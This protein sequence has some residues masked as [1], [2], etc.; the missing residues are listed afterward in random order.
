MSDSIHLNEKKRIKN[1]IYLL[2]F[3]KR[4]CLRDILIEFDKEIK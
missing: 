3:L 2:L 4:V 1:K